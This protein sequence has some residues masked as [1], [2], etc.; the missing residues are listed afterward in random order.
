[1]PDGKSYTGKQDVIVGFVFLGIAVLFLIKTFQLTDHE[2]AQLSIRQFPM[3]VSSVIVLLSLLLIG[4]GMKAMKTHRVRQRSDVPRP[5]LKQIVLRPF[6]LRFFGVAVLGVVYTRVF[7]HVGFVV[8]T[9]GLLAGAMLLFGHKKWY[10]IVIIPVV[11]SFALYH[12]FRTM[13]R[14]PLPVFGF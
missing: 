12:V 3:I 14:V 8:A 5:S 10:R 1:M 13:F 4:K 11:V 9:S 2:L 7:D 6:V